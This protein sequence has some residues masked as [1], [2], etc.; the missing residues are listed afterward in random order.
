[1]GITDS[2][3]WR[4]AFRRKP[5]S[6]IMHDARTSKLSKTLSVVSLTMLGIGFVIG[7][8]IFVL[9]GQA[10]AKYAG[11]ALSLSFVISVLLDS[12]VTHSLTPLTQS[13][14]CFLTGLSYAELA[15]AIPVT[16]SAY[17]LAVLHSTYIHTY[18]PKQQLHLHVRTLRRVHRMDSRAMSHSRVPLYGC[19]CC[20]RLVRDFSRAA[21]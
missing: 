5:M 10:A 20:C 15:A 19:S 17:V 8:G 6:L 14:A 3:S 13:I 16:G 12:S 7:S 9:T 4:I 18:T 21:V 1:M 11:P 2:E